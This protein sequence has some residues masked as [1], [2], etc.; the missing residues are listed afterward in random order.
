MVSPTS[1]AAAGG[2]TYSGAAARKSVGKG[3]TPGWRSR[4]MAFEANVPQSVPKRPYLLGGTANVISAGEKAVRGDENSAADRVPWGGKFKIWR[5]PN[6]ESTPKPT[7]P[8]L[9]MPATAALAPA[10]S[11]PDPS[12]ADVYLRPV[13]RQFK[14]AG[15]G[16]FGGSAAED[17][18]ASVLMPGA[19][20]RASSGSQ[21]ANPG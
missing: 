20:A 19:I 10:P 6:G 12:I 14:R 2:G 16:G 8:T 15:T 18:S 21:L 13:P 11:L 3:R 17:I 4:S 5:P 7:P 1:P 9:E